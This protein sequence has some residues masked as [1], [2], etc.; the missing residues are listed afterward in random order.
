MRAAFLVSLLLLSVFYAVL[1]F[2]S[3]NFLSA[4][5]RIAPGF[6][7]QIIATLL[8]ACTLYSTVI[9]FRGHEND[10]PISSDWQVSLG[11]AAMVGLLILTCQWLGA[12]PGMVLFMLLSLSVLNRGRHMT[13]FLVG[14]LLPAGL[15]ALF[16]YSLN[17]SMPP[18]ML[19]LPL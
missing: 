18:G 5:G 19:G 10:E 12:L 6:F 13:N 16:R 8:V 15:F 7:P 4:T 14:V 17:A 3:L 2:T 11:V 1:A 9:A